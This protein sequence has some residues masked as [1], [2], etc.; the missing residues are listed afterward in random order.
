MGFV[1]KLGVAKKHLFFHNKTM[2]FQKPSFSSVFCLLLRVLFCTFFTLA[3]RDAF[4]FTHQALRNPNTQA[5]LYDMTTKTVLFEKNADKKMAPSSMTKVLLV[6]MVFQKLKNAEAHL[7]DMFKVSARARYMRG[8]RMFLE[9]AS[10]VTLNRLLQGIIVHSGNDATVTLAEGLF[11]SEENAA[12]KGNRLAQKLG[13]CQ[14]H[15]LNMTG[16][17]DPGHLSTARDIL[18]LG[19]RTIEDFPDLYK[20]FYGQKVLTHNKI[21]Q[22]N[23][24]PLVHTALGDGLKTGTTERGGYGLL[25][26]AKRNGRRLVFVI[27]GLKSNAERARAS[28]A[29][30][31]WGFGRF[32]R[33]TL[34]KK[35]EV[36]GYAPVEEG[37]VE[38][39]PLIAQEDVAFS[40]P[41]GMKKYIKTKVKASLLK[42]PLKA[43]ELCGVLQIKMPDMPIKTVSLCAQKDVPRLSWLGR[44]WMH[45]YRTVQGFFAVEA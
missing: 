5:I 20:Q 45:I 17:P 10:H 26:S 41:S 38:K 6:Y 13:L 39:A 29:L 27:N 14:S 12:K 9:L 4:C 42:A 24:N 15:F 21:K 43:G 34:F 30:L 25:G 3:A 2:A 22:Y 33:T 37:K 28:V 19:V 44:A 32:E 11:G 36:I 1:G 31:N 16:W 18:H 8:S 40:Y 35:G 7:N 23:R